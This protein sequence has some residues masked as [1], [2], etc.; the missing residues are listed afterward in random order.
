MVISG[1]SC[2]AIPL[3]TSINELALPHL[4]LGLGVGAVDAA[5]VPMLANLVESR[6]SSHYGPVYALQQTAVNLAYSLGP[7]LGGQAVQTISFP[8]L[9]RLVGLLNILFCPLLL[10]LEP[11]KVNFKIQFAVCLVSMWMVTKLYTYFI[12]G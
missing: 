4:G 2:C 11:Q 3:A 8:W 7:F 6:G 12:F 9:M 1:L 5:L 10:E